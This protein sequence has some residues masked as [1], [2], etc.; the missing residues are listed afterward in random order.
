LEA[1][2]LVQADQAEEMAAQT[3]ALSFVTPFANEATKLDR[4]RSGHGS[5][6]MS[7]FRRIIAWKSA[8][9]SLASTSNVT[10]PSIAATITV[11]AFES[12]SRPTVSSRAIVLAE[13][14]PLEGHGGFNR[15][16][17]FGWGPKGRHYSGVAEAA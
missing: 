6:L 1:V 12:L 2:S 3:A 10:P 7:D 5:S 16:E 8:T 13:L 11:S 9:I 17:S 14:H 4:A 15:L